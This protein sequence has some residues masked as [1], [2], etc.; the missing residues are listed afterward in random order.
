MIEIPYVE[1]A[2]FAPTGLS[3]RSSATAPKPSYTEFQPGKIIHSTATSPN[4]ADLD[5]RQQS[6][7]AREGLLHGPLVSIMV[8]GYRIGTIPLGL[9]SATSVRFPELLISGAINLLA[10]TDYDGIMVLVQHLTDVCRSKTAQPARLRNN[11]PVYQSLAVCQ[12]AFRL[13]MTKYTRHV[14]RRMEA[15]ISNILLRY[16]DIDA[17][18]HF[19][20]S[21]PR[22]Y[23]RMVDRLTVMVRE[24]AIP[25]PEVFAQFC[26]A[27]PP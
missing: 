11:M 7:L 5:I 3:Y 21:H 15:Y 14:F 25:D 16:D 8:S 19:G 17:V 24:E 2:F 18:C 4:P 1:H 13:G 26:F 6:H 27:R 9:L 23:N 20:A 22:L 12:A 10:D